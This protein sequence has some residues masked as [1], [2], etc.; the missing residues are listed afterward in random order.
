MSIQ[1]VLFDVFGTVVDW[2]TSLIRQFQKFA[3]E[4][5]LHTDWANLADD[6]RA[7]YEPAMRAVRSGQRP[8]IN[9]ERLHREA[10]DKLLSVRG[11]SALNE[12]QRQQLVR[13]WHFLDP[14]PDALAGLK[15]LKRKYIIGTLS[16][17]GVRLLTD[18][19]RY[20]QL[21]WD[22]VLSSDLFR[23]YKPDPEVYLGAAEL[24]DSRPEDIVLAAAHNYDLAAARQHGMKT[25]FV[26]RPT[27]YG[28]RQSRDFTAE[29]DW[30]FV[31][32]DFEQMAARMDA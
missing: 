18:M 15:R 22:V 23:H 17:G 29:S 16:N 9:L 7:E 25:A 31:A 4:N 3:D 24:L 11:L 28:P 32:Q 1:A 21:P 5:S 27:E 2:R 8:W 14:W 30:D 13:A 20:A 26:A 12:T 10:L 6:W 19:A